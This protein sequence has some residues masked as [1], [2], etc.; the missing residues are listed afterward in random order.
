MRKL[1]ALA[2]PLL[3]MGC[4]A[5]NADYQSYLNNKNLRTP[6]PSSLQHCRGYGC[7]FKD[8]VTL[9]KA[10][11]RGIIKP[12]RVRASSPEKEREH[13][14]TVIAS[15]EKIMGEKTGTANDQWGTFRTMGDDQHDCVDE[16]TNTTIYLSLLEQAGLLKHHT[17]HGPTARFPII[18]AGRWPH[19][20][21]V[22][23]DDKNETFY[24]VD[25]WFHDNGEPP[26]I[27]PLKQWKEGWKPE[28]D[29]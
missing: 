8:E 14:K 18:H 16:S 29:T 5:S 2:L 20:T 15:F 27:I 4:G 22:I 17:L 24:A 19:F 12:L 28:R 26:E 25:S 11:W 6:L 21:A 10:E 7:K 13:I 23:H 1:L 3:L 9:T